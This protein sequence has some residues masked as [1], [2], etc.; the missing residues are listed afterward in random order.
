M[1]KATSANPGR[2]RIIIAD[3]SPEIRAIIE[4]RLLQHY[5]V[6]SKV[7]DGLQL[8]ESV[9]SLQPD[10]FVTDIS[11]PGISGIEVLRRLRSQ[12][13]NIPAVILTVHEDQELLEA[14]LSHGALGFVLK[15][16]IDRDLLPAIQ[17]AL[18]GRVFISE[19]M[20]A[21]DI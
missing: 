10:I 8:I 11:M 9:L 4:M 20:R 6:V 16:R 13:I 15:S 2:R 7:E 12:Q 17:Q 18:E 19:R 21:K 3:D 14:S 1:G 5:D